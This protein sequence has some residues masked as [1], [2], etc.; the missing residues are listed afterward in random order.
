MTHAGR[1]S[2][3]SRIRGRR[4]V[5]A[6]AGILAGVLVLPCLVLAAGAPAAAGGAGDRAL[7]LTVTVNGRGDGGERPTPVRAGSEVVKRYRLV[8]RG[9][10]DL[11]GVRVHDPGNPEGVTVRCPRRT[12]VGLTSMECAARF[13]ALPGTRTATV[14]AEGRIPS[15]GLAATATARGG[16]AGVLGS[17]V[18]GERVRL[19]APATKGAATVTY[20]VANRGNRP[21]YDVR[22]TDPGLGLAGR[23]VDCGAGPLRLAP[24]A[25][26]R[27]TATVRRPPGVHRSTGLAT[28]TDRVATYAPDGRRLAAPLLTARSGASF[29]VPR[30]EPE[31]VREGAA[32][33]GP[34]GAPGARGV[35][36]APGAPGAPGGAAVAP[37]PP[38]T[39]VLP[40]GPPGTDALPG[41][42]EAAGLG[43]AVA[44]EG[45]GA[46]AGAGAGLVE[47]PPAAP[48]A[49]AAPEEPGATGD[50]GGTGGTGGTSETGGTGEASTG[51]RTPPDTAARRTA[52]LD[53]EG[54]LGRLRRRGREADEMGVVVMLLLI[55]VPAAL[56][57]ALLGN[58]RT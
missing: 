26:A 40:I 20:T 44:G 48:A 36:G 55:L 27:C 37:V 50:T 11:H 22:V 8:N 42:D 15:L 43:A 52:T 34:S 39:D 3:Y 10:A 24:G 33:A 1:S 53:G 35:S 54:F 2:D 13:R 47:P 58:R 7:R 9:G 28:G 41:L 29:T 14:R 5:R 46:G 12:L 16:Y 57:A 19:A 31:P 30:P 17:L 21:L 38:L 4:A 6:G 49:P 18:L 32:V 51:G 45:E 23:G 25:S 56:A